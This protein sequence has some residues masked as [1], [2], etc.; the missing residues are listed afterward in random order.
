MTDLWARALGL[1][2]D[3][4]RGTLS[5]PSLL[6]VSLDR[7]EQHNEE[8]ERGLLPR[9]RRGAR[10]RRRSTPRSRRW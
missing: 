10:P 2:D 1:A 9:R 7:I 4:A 5:R 3:V 6:E 8:P